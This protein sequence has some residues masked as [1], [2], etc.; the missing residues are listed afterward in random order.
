MMSTSLKYATNQYISKQLCSRLSI[1][2][3][4]L[5][6]LSMIRSAIS[7]VVRFS[8][9]TWQQSGNKRVMRNEMFWSNS[10]FISSVLQNSLPL[11]GK[12]KAGKNIFSRQFGK[13]GNNLVV[14]HICRQPLQ[15]IVNR[16]AGIP[17]A[18][19]SKTFFG[20]DSDNVVKTVHDRFLFDNYFAK[21]QK[22]Q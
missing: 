18:G 4:I 21:V 16:D 3:A 19:F 22:K 5:E 8:A 17:H 14:C 1:N 11:S 7:D 6:A 10:S 9:R 15:Y 20:I 2:E 13:I 12:G